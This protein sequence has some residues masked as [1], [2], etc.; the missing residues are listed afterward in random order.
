MSL[1][2][3][4][5]TNSETPNL[6]PK[7]INTHAL[8]VVETL[9]RKGFTSFIV[10]GCVRDLM[11]GIIP[12][13]FDLVTEARPRQ[14][15]KNIHNAF[16]IGKRFR[17]VLVKRGELQ[18]EVATFRRNKK[19]SDIDVIGEDGEPIKKGDNYFGSPQ[20]DAERRDFT[21]NA[22]FYDPSSGDVTDYSTG[23]KDL[24]DRIIRIIGNPDIRIE[25]DPIRIFRAIRLAHKLKFTIEHKFK[26]SISANA[27]MIAN[28]VLPRRR[29]EFLKLL[30]LKNPSAAFVEAK[31]LGILKH[32]APIIDQAL[33]SNEFILRLRE[34]PECLNH[35]STTQLFSFLIWAY[36]R[37]QVNPDPK[38]KCKSKNLLEDPKLKSLMRDELGMFNYEQSICCKALQQQAELSEIVTYPKDKLKVYTQKDSYPT[39]LMY[40]KLDVSLT[41]KEFSFLQKFIVNAS[42]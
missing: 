37:S 8:K 26:K 16:I 15:K 14:I 35:Q 25:E 3:Y 4:I 10:G 39:A 17:L 9:Q 21:I 32:I 36:Y 13:D 33:E 2:D 6:S 18:I 42:S 20:E 24:N 38:V 41:A 12:K 11:L 1:L 23:L 29:E 22:L 28:S 5:M 40:A 7:W 19:D 31:D 27:Q 30:K 34:K